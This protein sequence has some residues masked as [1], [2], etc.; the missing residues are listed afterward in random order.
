MGKGNIREKRKGNA[1]GRRREVGG[2]VDMGGD[3]VDGGERER[4]DAGG[5]DWIKGKGKGQ[6]NG[7][8]RYGKGWKEKWLQRRG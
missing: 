4:G 6:F 1:R 3:R 8:V 5:K 2:G 7:I